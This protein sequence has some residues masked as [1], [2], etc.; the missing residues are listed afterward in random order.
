MLKSGLWSNDY[1]GGL[2]TILEQLSVEIESKSTSAILS[3]LIVVLKK[4][5]RN[6]MNMKN[7]FHL[8]QYYLNR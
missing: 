7:I 6:E 4:K 2:G 1:D 5:T 8:T 3:C